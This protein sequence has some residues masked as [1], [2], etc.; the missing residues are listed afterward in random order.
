MFAVFVVTE[1]SS[2]LTGSSLILANLTHDMAHYSGGPAWVVRYNEAIWLSGSGRYAEAKTLLAPLL[3]DTTI[4]KRADIAELYGDLIYTTSGSIDDTIHMYNRSLSF[5][6]SD[7]LIAKIAYI[8][9][10]QQQS[11]T[12]SGTPE[13]SIKIDSGSV[14]RETKKAE[15]QKT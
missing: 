14:E 2:L 3:N 13:K 11:K 7:R 4:E 6:S 9:M 1:R 8:K 10:I 12:G 5:S 15:L